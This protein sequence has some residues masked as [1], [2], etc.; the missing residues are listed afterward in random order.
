MR[1]FYGSFVLAIEL[2]SPSNLIGQRFT[3]VF[4]AC[5]SCATSGDLSQGWHLLD[6]STHIYRKDRYSACPTLR[7]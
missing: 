1:M 2:G 4:A 5:E 7:W 3:S 6:T